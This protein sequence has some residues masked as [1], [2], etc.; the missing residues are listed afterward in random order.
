MC[1]GARRPLVASNGLRLSICGVLV[2]SGPTLP[3]MPSA[4]L[5]GRSP[6]WCARLVR[7]SV[8]LLWG[9]GASHELPAPGRHP[10]AGSTQRALG[11]FA[12]PS[13]DCGLFPRARPR[14]RS[15][16][17]RC[18]AAI[19]SSSGRIVVA[20]L[21]PADRPPALRV[22]VPRRRRAHWGLGGSQQRR[23]AAPAPRTWPPRTW[24]ACRVAS[25]LGRA[26][27][28]QKPCAQGVGL[29]QREVRNRALHLVHPDVA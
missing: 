8:F 5:G 28:P 29:A 10:S 3:G 2:C 22:D 23:V 11:G 12:R 9:R 21:S 13:S 24:S 4:S 1:V 18:G 7:V 27:P 16:R 20:D 25:R 6:Y 19:V 14:S 15:G 26:R 17:G